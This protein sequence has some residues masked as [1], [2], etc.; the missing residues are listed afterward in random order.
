MTREIIETV[1][2]SFQTEVLPREKVRVLI[3]YNPDKPEFAHYN[4]AVLGEAGGLLIVARR[5]SLDKVRAGKPD[6]GHLVVYRSTPNKV[7]EIGR[8]DLSCCPSVINWEDPRAFTSG[9]DVLI[10]LTAIMASGNK[11]V[12]ATVRGQ[13]IEGNFRIDT[14]SLAVFPYDE[15]KNTTPVSLGTV[16]FRRN[17]F[18]HLLELARV[19]RGSETNQDRLEVRRTIEFP[20]RPWCE[21]QMGTQ[22]Q[23]LPN[24]ILPIHGTNRFVRRINPKTGQVEYGYTYSLGLAQLDE[25]MNVIKVPDE[26]LFTRDSFENILPMGKEMDPDKE[27]VYCCGYSFDGEIVTFIVNIGDL[28]TVEVKKKFSELKYMLEITKTIAREELEAA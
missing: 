12:A 15:G 27:V 5:V 20:K 25:K 21:W 14:K 8:L 10:G 13:I 11:P 1:G 24:G 18:P 2:R 9:K 23:M 16:L 26:P 19:V 17:G 3:P 7:E 6:M 22:A 4:A 28:M